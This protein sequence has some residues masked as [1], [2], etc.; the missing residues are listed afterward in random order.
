MANVTRV[1]VGWE[2]CEQSIP[3]GKRIE[4]RSTKYSTTN[5]GEVVRGDD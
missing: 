2:M 3:D 1:G 4:I 5:Q